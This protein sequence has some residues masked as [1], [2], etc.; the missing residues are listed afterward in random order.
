M[1]ERSLLSEDRGKRIQVDDVTNLL[2]KRGGGRTTTNGQLWGTVPWNKEMRSFLVLKAIHCKAHLGSAKLT[3]FAWFWNVTTKEGFVFL[4]E[5]GK[6]F[7]G[8]GRRRWW[9]WVSNSKVI[10][11]IMSSDLNSNFSS[12][13]GSFTVQCC[14][15]A[16]PELDTSPIN[17]LYFYFCW[18]GRVVTSLSC[19]RRQSAVAAAP[20]T[21]AETPG[22]LLGQLSRLAER[23]YHEC[24]DLKGFFDK[25]GNL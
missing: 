8:K 20:S 17:R 12:C 2:A 5:R 18:S 15:A 25:V 14:S 10:R 24:R 19:A 13:F 7:V 21:P 6:L 4:R 16:I 3:K 11:F 9:K 23:N 1:W 22:G